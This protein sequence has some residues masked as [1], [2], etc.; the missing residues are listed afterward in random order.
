MEDDFERQN[1]ALGVPHLEIAFLA[2]QHEIGLR[3]IAGLDLLDHG[4]RSEPGTQF[5]IG[6]DVRLKASLDR[7]VLERIDDV[8]HHANRALHVR[9]AATEDS[10]AILADP[11]LVRAADPR[12]GVGNRHGVEVPVHGDGRAGGRIAD[13]HDDIRAVRIVGND[14]DIEIALGAPVGNE[15]HHGLFIATR[16]RD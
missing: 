1:A 14:G 12:I 9:R 2:D 6:N 8:H 7:R 13:R 4:Q 5:F 10:L 3:Q 15:I 11:R 16:T